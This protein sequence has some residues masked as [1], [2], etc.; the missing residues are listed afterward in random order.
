MRHQLTSDAGIPLLAFVIE[1]LNQD[2]R[3]C[4]PG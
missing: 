1:A 2:D 3:R 4:F